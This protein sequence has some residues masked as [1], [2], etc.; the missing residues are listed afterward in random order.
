MP[1]NPLS[2][3]DFLATTA[4]GIAG[5]AAGG[6]GGGGG[7]DE[8]LVHVGTYTEGGRREGIYRF[9][10]NPADGTL[11]PAGAA[12][13][14]DNPSFLALH[15][16]GRFLYAVN[17]VTEYGGEPSGAVSSFTVDPATGQLVLLDRR[18]SRGGAPCYISVDGTG[19]FALVANYVGGSVA[20]LPIAG[21]GR[22]GEASAVVQH[23]GS[24]PN[25]ERQSGPH[26]HCV[27]LDPS[28]R[29]ALVA[30]LGIDRIMVY[31]FDAGAGTLTPAAAPYAALPPGA[32][33]RHL[34]FHP[35]GR[36]LY[37]VNEL[38][39]TLVAFGYDAATGA[40]TAVQTLPLVPGRPEGETLGADLHLLPS[41]R[42]L[43]AS[44]RGDNSVAVFA[45]G[46]AAGTLTPVQRVS[47][48]G[49]WP[50]N[51]AIDPTG[52]F[53]LVANQRSNTIVGFRV[54][55]A[56]GRLTETGQRLEVPAPVCLRFDGRPSR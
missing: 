49:D 36:F 25:A 42:F 15:P 41:G 30:D 34:A 37:L 12:V 5:Y 33:P 18:A 24:G 46:Q 55:P 16:T 13:A 9:R 21:D 2:R 48:G 17:E 20:V 32:G 38:D 53:L 43:Y 40:L 1:E 35:G 7:A 54:D 26:A 52:R 3:R 4:V 23:R 47:T 45:V 8:P 6:A 22:L 50:R 27:I 11:R 29:F 28:N 44:V 39:L 51:F 56:T 31:R 19:R 10:M 14:G